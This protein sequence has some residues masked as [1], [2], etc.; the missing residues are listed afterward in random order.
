MKNILV[1]DDDDGI[2]EALELI[3]QAEG[4]HVLSAST[5]KQ[6]FHLYRTEYPDLVLFDF[7][8]PDLNGQDFLNA[9]RSHERIER[10]TTPTA[11]ILFSA[12]SQGQAKAR[13]LG[14]HWLGKPFEIYDLLDVVEQLIGRGQ[15]TGELVAVGAGR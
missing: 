7:M 10:P 4:Y 14:V 15:S 1:I 6:G 12:T 13:E 5:A 3:L 8:M 9:V 2:L 11:F